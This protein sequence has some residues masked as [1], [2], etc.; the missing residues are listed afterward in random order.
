[1]QTADF[2]HED[3]STQ[4]NK[5]DESLLVK[6]FFKTRRK[7][8]LAPHENAQFE[9]AEYIEI[10]VC[11]N[12]DPQACRPATHADKQRFPRHYAAFKARTE[13][14]E[15]GFP[16]AEWPLINRSMVETL[17]F[18]HVKTVEQ[19]A[20]L[21]D[22]ALG[23]IMGGQDFKRKAQEWLKDRNSND[24]LARENDT[25]KSQMAEM[26]AQMA[27]LLSANKVADGEPKT[28]NSEVES[29]TENS[30]VE[31]KA[32]NLEVEPKAEPKAKPATRRSRA[33]AK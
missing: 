5:A 26:Q 7:K 8:G 32:E 17:S 1:M 14:P 3:F 6:F 2:N 29:K 19:L 18:Q 13:M 31:P 20:N 25:L 22:S 10:R 27:E 21:N 15:D 4:S 28:E 30:E 33:K 16:L 24:S 11:G 12:R 23:A 9:E